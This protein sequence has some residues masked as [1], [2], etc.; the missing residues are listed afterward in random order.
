M[1]PYKLQRNSKHSIYC[2]FVARIGK[3]KNLHF[4]F[5]LILVKP[6]F[7]GQSL[8]IGEIFNTTGLCSF[9]YIKLFVSN[10]QLV[11]LYR[12]QR[13]IPILLYAYKWKSTGC[14]KIHHSV[15]KYNVK[16]LTKAL[17]ENVQNVMIND[18]T[19][20]YM[21]ASLN[22]DYDTYR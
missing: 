13:H 6:H 21:N 17:W 18:H 3:G 12:E 4:M 9:F 15:R 14:F 7:S 22:V 10:L 19:S 5:I 20:I 2:M 8:K 11:V 1:Q 16:C